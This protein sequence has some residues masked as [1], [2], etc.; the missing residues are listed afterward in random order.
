MSVSGQNHFVGI[1]SGVSW[2]NIN[3]DNNNDSRIGFSAGLSYEL[4]LKEHFSFGAD[5]IYNQRGFSNTITFRDEYGN[6]TG[7]KGTFKSN[8]DYLSIPIKT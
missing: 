3:S 4:F 2:T 6:A 5:I 1:K 8:Y 7:Q